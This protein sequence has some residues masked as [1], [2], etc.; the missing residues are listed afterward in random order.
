MCFLAFSI[1]YICVLMYVCV[2]L[3]SVCLSKVRVYIRAY[4]QY[5]HTYI[6]VCIHTY[7]PGQLLFGH[8]VQ[9]LLDVCSAALHLAG[10]VEGGGG[11]DFIRKKLK[12]E[13]E[14]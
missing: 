9:L 10:G 2:I 6:I 7:I 11:A 13:V 1:Q 5:I 14:V 12:L 8:G 3:Y 4:I